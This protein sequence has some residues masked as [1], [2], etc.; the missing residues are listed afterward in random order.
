MI[1]ILY[2]TIAL[3]ALVF[4]TWTAMYVARFRLIKSNPPTADTFRSGSAARAYFEP[5]ELPANNFAN[6]F[7]MPVLYFALIPLLLFTGQAG[8]AQIAL[9]WAYVALR[10]LHTFL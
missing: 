2:P 9:A 3:V 10:A 1:A 5:S 4:V 7:E 6:L 8:Q